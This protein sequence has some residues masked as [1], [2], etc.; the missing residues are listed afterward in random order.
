LSDSLVGLI[1]SV[2]KGLIGNYGAFFVVTPL[3]VHALC[4]YFHAFFGI[5]I[6][7]GTIMATLQVREI[8]DRLYE[9]IKTSAKLQNRSISQEVITILQNYCTSSQKQHKNAT[10]EFLALTGAWHDDQDAQAI[11]DKI[12]C[13]RNN[14]TRFGANNGIFD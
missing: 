3:P 14:S 4:L 8:D 6:N 5:L 11:V 7:G 13:N 1:D 9:F 2:I 10:E 12:R